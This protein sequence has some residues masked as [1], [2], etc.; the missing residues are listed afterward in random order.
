MKI[1]F[2]YVPFPILKFRRLYCVDIPCYGEPVKYSVYTVWL[3][4]KEVE[5]IYSNENSRNFIIDL[6][7][8]M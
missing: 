2:T 8:N 3:E 4:G 1:S 6:I 5:W 7:T